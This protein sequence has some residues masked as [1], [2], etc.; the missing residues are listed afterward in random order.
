MEL[1][2]RVYNAANL[3]AMRCLSKTAYIVLMY[4][5]C[6]AD[7][8][9]RCF[10]SAERIAQDI[11]SHE[12]V[13]YKT[14]QILEDEKYIGYLRRNAQDP[15]TGRFLPNVYIVNPLFICLAEENQ[16]Q[17]ENLWLQVYPN[18]VPTFRH[19]IGTNQ[20][21]EPAPKTNTIESV[22]EINTIESPPPTTNNN[23]RTFEKGDGQS[24]Q[25]A[26]SSHA[27][28]SKRTKSEKQK[29]KEQD[30]SSGEKQQSKAQQRSEKHRRSA[31]GYA[32]PE[33]VV[34]PIDDAVQE[35]LANRV[36][37]LGIPIRL[38]R[39]FVVEYG[40]SLVETA[41]LYLAAAKK[42]GQEFSSEAGFFRH[43]LQNN[44][45]DSSLPETLIPKWTELSDF[46]DDY[47]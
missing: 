25:S 31:A 46:E 43:L 14:L 21:Q 26:E 11:G 16:S 22:P 34:A 38:A 3:E 5:V 33:A 10:P 47:L 8:L 42:R 20:Q 45:V 6:R 17:A 27:Q 1:H 40:A 32:Q 28:K 9:G 41:L 24:P 19:F 4:L 44:F 18:F 37:L 29:A 12:D 15:I 39:G 13:V 23:N 36:K 30:D 2:I 35:A 7:S